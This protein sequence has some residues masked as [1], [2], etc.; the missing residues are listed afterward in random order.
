MVLCGQAGVAQVSVSVAPVLHSAIVVE[1]QLLG[2]DERN[3]AA[4]QAL[5]KHQQPPDTTIPFLKWVNAFKLYMKIQN[6]IELYFF[7]AVVF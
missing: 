7:D 2:D 4:L 1:S 5:P 3:V 6:A